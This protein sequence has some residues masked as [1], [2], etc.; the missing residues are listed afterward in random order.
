MATMLTDLDL[1]GRKLERVPPEVFSL[2]HLEGLNLSRNLLR[3]MDCSR[4]R[5]VGFL[6][7]LKRLDVSRNHLV[8]FPRWFHQLSRASHLDFSANP[9]S[10]EAF[11]KLPPEFGWRTNRLVMTIS[12]SNCQLKNFPTEI[13]RLRNLR[14]IFAS[15]M[16]RIYKLPE[17]LFTLKNLSTLSMRRGGLIDLPTEFS[18]L[19]RLKLLDLGQN[20]LWSFP[21]CL[22]QMTA[23]EEVWFDGNGLTFMPFD[24]GQMFSLKMLHL[25]GN[26]LSNLPDIIPGSLKLLDAY[27][28]I[29]F[30][31]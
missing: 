14:K 28:G 15:N 5:K 11:L 4:K 2:E 23:L 1:S 18:N 3:D 24:L 21:C 22:C 10:D 27:K 16:E 25:E 8:A 29:S 6:R 17:K 30:F 31:L 26:K 19:Q 12:L 9:I 20:R 13:C 7:T